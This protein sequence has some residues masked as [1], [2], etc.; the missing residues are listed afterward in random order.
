M[1][2]ISFLLLEIVV[3][4]V[5]IAILILFGAHKHIGLPGKYPQYVVE[6]KDIDGLPI[7]APVRVSGLHVG[8][9]VKQE[10]KDDKIL[11]TFKITDENIKIPIGSIAGVE[12]TG[13]ASSKSLEI[14]PPRIKIVSGR[15]LYTVEPL[16]ANSLLE[17]QSVVVKTTIDFLDGIISFI[18]K[19]EKTIGPKLKNASKLFKEKTSSLEK[20]EKLLKEKTNEAIQETKELTELVKGTCEN[21]EVIHEAVNNF[22]TDEETKNRIIKI[23]ESAKNL[24]KLI[25]SGESQKKLDE[26]NRKAKKINGDLEI[27]N[28]KIDKVKNR[29]VAYIKEFSESLKSV[30][31]KM[32]KI[33]DS[34]EKKLDS[35]K[36]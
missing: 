23:K 17:I 19:N 15:Q 32:Q 33:I 31:E 2:K 13:L 25:Q 14:Q 9:V 24:N 12:F 26:I 20:T 16:R 10:L 8:H 7:G 36:K 1:K 4:I 3:V 35:E 22:V 18:K 6:F 30:T 29:E 28:K 5:V 11:I 34:S 21:V 27:L